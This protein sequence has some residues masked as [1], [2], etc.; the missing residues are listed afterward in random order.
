MMH[1]LCVVSQSASAALRPAK[2]WG[3][4]GAVS[5][6]K[7]LVTGCVGQ[8]LCHFDWARDLS[9]AASVRSCVIGTALTINQGLSTDSLHVACKHS[10]CV[11][12]VL[13]QLIWFVD[14][15]GL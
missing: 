9:G 1:G 2:G 12:Q 5:F 3:L 4:S 7:G 15:S 8:F 6:Q 13:C 14:P 10:G 11:G